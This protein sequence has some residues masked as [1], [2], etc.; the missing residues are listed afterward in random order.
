ME[1]ESRKLPTKT[2]RKA[3]RDGVRK[4][5][6]AGKAQGK[7]QGREKKSGRHVDRLRP[8][9]SSWKMHPGLTGGDY[10]FPGTCALQMDAAHWALGGQ[11]V[12]PRNTIGKAS[13]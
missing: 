9:M 10:I 8:T 13:T 1:S 3:N 7:R 2:L 12:M 6:V 4:D 5:T 11:V